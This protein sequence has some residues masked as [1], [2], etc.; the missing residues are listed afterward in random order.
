MK[1]LENIDLSLNYLNTETL[2]DY[3]VILNYRKLIVC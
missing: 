3:T 2:F 1:S